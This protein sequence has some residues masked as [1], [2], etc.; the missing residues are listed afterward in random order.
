MTSAALARAHLAEWRECNE[1]RDELI[2]EAHAAGLS[3]SDIALL[4]GVS[5][6]TVRRVL[7]GRN[8]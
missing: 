6:S 2:R 1:R 8:Q 7:W 5:R 3:E 4:S